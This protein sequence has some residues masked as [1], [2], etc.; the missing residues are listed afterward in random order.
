MKRKNLFLS[1]LLVLG[2]F[3][4]GCGGASTSDSESSTEE[5]TTEDTASEEDLSDASL[6]ELI[7]KADGTTVSFYGWGGDEALN[8][9]LDEVYAVQLEE[10]YNITLD[11]VPMDIEEVLNILSTEKQAGETEG[12]VDMIWI[13]GENFQTAMENDFLYGPF[14]HQLDNF[15]DY[16]D[17]EDPEH[18]Q[19][20]GYP[21]DGHEAPYGKAQFVLIKDEAVTEETPENAEELLEFAQ[22][23]EGQVTYPALPDFTG[24]AFVRNI[25]YEFVDPSEFEDMEA[26]KEVVA[27]AIE[28]AFEYLR[29]LNPYLWNEGQTFPSDQP[30]LNNMFMDGEVV[31]MMS[32]GA[33]DVAVAIENGEYRETAQSF[34]FE[35]GTLGNTNFI[36]IAGNSTN[37]AG[38][39]VAINEMLSPEMQASKYEQL[40][41]LPVLDHDSLSEEQQALFDEVDPGPGTIPQ[42]ELL[43][44][45]LPEMPGELVPIIEELWLEE[46]VGQYN[47]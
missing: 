19:D 26:D 13:N 14:T 8:R 44:A 31:L 24:S 23:Y 41:T 22:T 12:P 40:R 27:E 42:D 17:E 21:I 32:Y 20:F 11:R 4:A 45:R 28:P 39:M 29:E 43:S 33:Y 6:E 25:I 2:L 47:E 46:V 37:K 18:Q 16:V 1:V 15:Q 34:I 35:N 5:T 36:A 7:E 3:L 38:A 9:W 10:N 30:Q